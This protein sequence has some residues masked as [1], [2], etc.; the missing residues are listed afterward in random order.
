MWLSTW[1]SRWFYGLLGPGHF[2]GPSG[3]L[4]LTGCLCRHGVGSHL[5][6]CPPQRVLAGLTWMRGGA[7]YCKRFPMGPCFEAGLCWCYKYRLTRIPTCK[8]RLGEHSSASGR[9]LYV[10]STTDN[11]NPACLCILLTKTRGVT[12]V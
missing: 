11:V 12:V 4:V 2:F 7:S 5:R 8:P 10:S 1:R 9:C 3:R 6:N